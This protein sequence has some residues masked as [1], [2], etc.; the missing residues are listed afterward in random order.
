MMTSSIGTTL[1]RVS[2]GRVN[3]KNVLKSKPLEVLSADLLNQKNV[4]HDC[5]SGNNLEHN[6]R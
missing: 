2:K 5:V 4:K 1:K 6:L 3:I